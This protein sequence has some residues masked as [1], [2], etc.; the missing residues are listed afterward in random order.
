VV[1]VVLPPL[2]VQLVRAALP[3]Q[4]VLPAP[5]LQLD[6]QVLVGPQ[7]PEVRSFGSSPFFCRYLR[8]L[9]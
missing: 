3:L 9:L 4:A 2:V 7:A 8:S 6:R 5:Q 1:P